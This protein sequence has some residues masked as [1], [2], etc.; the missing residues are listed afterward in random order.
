MSNELLF[1]ITAAVSFLLV[2]LSFRLYGKAG[3]FVWLGFATVVANIEVIKCV[4][5]FSL[6]VTLGNVLYGST[7]LCTD[8]MSELF[9]GKESRR[10]VRMGFFALICFTIL[11][12]IALRFIPNENDFAS[13]AMHELFSLSPRI[14]IAS[15]GAYLISNTLDT[16]TFDWIG[17]HTKILWIKNNGST[18][19]SQLVDSIL[20]TF[21]AFYGLFEIR[22]LWLLVLTTYLI[23]IFIAMID[24]PFVYWARN[25]WNKYHKDK[26][27]EGKA[28]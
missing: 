21:G 18:M 14:C 27:P 23:K 16:Y 28:L 19:T 22:E 24:T 1:F 17:K 15:L 4:D 5:I 11:M 2:I 7:F 6:P 10:G 9:G 13:P 8:I 3:L 12:Q 20:F 26:E 25:I